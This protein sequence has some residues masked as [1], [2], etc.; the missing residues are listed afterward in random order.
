VFLTG[1]D[2]TNDSGPTSAAAAAA[3]AAAVAAAARDRERHSVGRDSGCNEWES[4]RRDS[5]DGPPFLPPAPMRVSLGRREDINPYATFR[6]P[7]SNGKGGGSG[8]TGS[9]V[10]GPNSTP[11]NGPVTGQGL[12]PVH[13]HPLQSPQH[14]ICMVSA[15][16]EPSWEKSWKVYRGSPSMDRDRNIMLDVIF[17]QL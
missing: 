17:T 12:S 15:Y 4:S 6:L 1:P 3:A 7:G 9:S 14:T 8:Q 13:R 2:L 5:D 10:T 11:S 16:E